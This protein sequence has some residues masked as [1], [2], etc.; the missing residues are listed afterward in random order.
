[1]QGYHHRKRQVV[2]RRSKTE[3]KLVVYD[4]KAGFVMVLYFKVKFYNKL[5]N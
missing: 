3:W 5:V 1:M 2:V 4:F